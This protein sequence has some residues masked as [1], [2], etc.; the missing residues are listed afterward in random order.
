VRKEK[1]EQVTAQ[2]VLVCIGRKP[3]TADLFA[4]GVTPEMNRGFLVVDPDTY[5]TSIPHIYAIGDA[6]GGIQLAHKA[7]AEG[8]AAVSRLYGENPAVDPKFV[9]SCVYTEPEI[10]SVGMT[11]EEAKERD[12]P[13]KTGKYLMSGNGKSIIDQQERGFIKVVVEENTDKLIGVQMMCGRASDLISEYTMAIANGMTRRELLKGMRPHPSYC[14][15]L[16]EALEA[17]CGES[18]HSMPVAKR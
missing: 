9:P 15:G 8:Q 5:R 16:T 10:A 11:A 14:E 12:I 1:E 13:V 3:N 6:I 18:I 17:V 2:G 4:E 7:S